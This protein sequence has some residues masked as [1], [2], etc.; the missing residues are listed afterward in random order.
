MASS[1]PRPATPGPGRP[2]PSRGPAP[3]RPSSRRRGQPAAEP[4]PR[5]L[6]A[7]AVR[8]GQLVVLAAVLV[9]ICL[10]LSGIFFGVVGLLMAFG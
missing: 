4:A 2:A 7:F 9:P 6:R 8:T 10:I 3:Q 5:G 1:S